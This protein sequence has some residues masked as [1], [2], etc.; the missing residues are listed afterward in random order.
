[1]S[2]LLTVVYAL[3]THWRAVCP[4]FLFGLVL[5][6]LFI[7]AVWLNVGHYFDND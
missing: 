2:D 1:M 7:W 4:S 5:S 3:A 6:S